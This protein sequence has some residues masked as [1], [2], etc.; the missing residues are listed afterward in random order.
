MGTALTPFTDNE[1]INRLLETVGAEQIAADD[2]LSD[3]SL[4]AETAYTNLKNSMRDLMSHPWGFNTE[5][6]VVLTPSTNKITIADNVANVDLAARDAGDLDVVVREETA[7]NRKLYDRKTHAFDAFTSESYKA[8]VQYYLDFEDCPEVVKM[9]IVAMAAVNFQ[10]SQVGNAQI[11]QILRAQLGAAKAAFMSYEAAQEAY[12]IFD[13]YDLF[14]IVQGG[15]R[16][17]IG[18]YGKSWWGGN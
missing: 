1:A 4:I 9:F 17:V 12:S 6:E 15:D 2:N 7:G 5:Y 3:L 16:P 18:G 14:K 13:N 8:T 10:A 11:D